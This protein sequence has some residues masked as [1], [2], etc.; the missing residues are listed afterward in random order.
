MNNDQRELI[1]AV[2]SDNTNSETAKIDTKWKDDGHTLRVKGGDKVTDP[3]GLSRSIL[4]V[5]E[6]NPTECYVKVL[7]V[8]P[9]ALNIVL[10][11]YRIAQS[12]IKNSTDGTILAI[13]QSEYFTD[14]DGT[15]ARVVCTRI[16]PISTKMVP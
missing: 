12:V 6:G 13:T 4:H 3:V 1:K 15:K 14:I 8:G 5:M 2:S 9:V 11:A 10:K 7:S 16:F